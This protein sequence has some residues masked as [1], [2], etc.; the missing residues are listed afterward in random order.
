MITEKRDKSWA[1]ADYI[2]VCTLIGV[3]N[4]GVT[5]TYSIHAHELPHKRL[6]AG[7]SLVVE[8]IIN[9]EWKKRV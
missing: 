5:R 9:Q 6:C 7:Q 1:M 3:L 2:A 8:D 4:S